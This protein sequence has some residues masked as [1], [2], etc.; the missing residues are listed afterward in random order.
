MIV[1]FEISM[2]F[3]V[4]IRIVVLSSVVYRRERLSRDIFELLIIS[5]ETSMVLNVFVVLPSESL[6]FHCWF[7]DVSLMT[8]WGNID[9]TA[10]FPMQTLM[11]IIV[12]FDIISETLMFHCCSSMIVKDSLMNHWSYSENFVASINELQGFFLT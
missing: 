1:T 3:S 8:I 4:R 12:F 9:V 7:L 5:L 10:M 6:F 2:I 11:I